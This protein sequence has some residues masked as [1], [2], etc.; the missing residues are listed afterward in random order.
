[1]C[2]VIFSK[3][4]NKATHALLLS[5][6]N[7]FAANDPLK[8]TFM[9]RIT[10][11]LAACFILLFSC[12]QES[13]ISPKPFTASMLAKQ[14]F[15]V[16]PARDTILHTLHGSAI[17]IRA[18]SFTVT[19]PIDIEIREAF[20]PSEILAAG[21]TTTSNGRPL[22]SAG[23]IY[24]NATANGDSIAISKPIDISIPNK[25]FDEEM[26][27][28]KGIQT[29]STINWT[30]PEP[31]DTTPQ[32]KNWQAGR[33][34]FQASCSPCHKLGYD[35]TGP[36][37]LNV[38]DRWA[39]R[40]D[41]KRWIL[42]WEEVVA[43][44]I[45]RAL[46][47][48]NLKPTAM[49]KFAYASDQQL[50][51]LLWYIRNES[52]KPHPRIASN[53]IINTKD[54]GFSDAICN[55]TI[56]I[57]SAPFDKSFFDSSNIEDNPALPAELAV[58]PPAPGTYYDYFPTSGMYTFR[59]TANGWYN[60]DAFLDDEDAIPVEV[61]AQVNT[62]IEIDLQVFLFIPARKIS[63]QPYG[64][65]QNEYM[66]NKYGPT[67]IRLFEN[68]KAILMAT[69]SKD[70]KMYYGIAEF[71]IQPIQTI[72]II[73]KESNSSEIRNAL[74]SKQMEGIDFGIE[75]NEMRVRK[76]NCE[77]TPAVIDPAANK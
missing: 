2:K 36:D 13:N 67:P 40:N 27:V 59:I 70:D 15:T 50:E 28:F 68:D 62:N 6:A 14:E 9:K 1:L 54:T 26:Q 73:L 24:I 23:M 18:G 33:A 34:I 10:V 61:R 8:T 41:I 4:L 47:A 60:I 58:P 20:T 45:P 31:A 71:Y 51:Q 65:N 19:S 38:E 56:Y 46:E 7:G 49:V 76:N 5:R 32:S 42:N 29:D 53:D 17:S 30:S 72:P 43:A 25:F 66:F 37:L 75:K 16:D 57:P 63:L 35:M 21:L 77:P 74:L 3:I 39:N 44:G 69:G 55:D 52:S 64:R 11:F 12:K 22:R 48:V